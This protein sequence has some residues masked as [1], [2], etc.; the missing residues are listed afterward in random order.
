MMMNSFLFRTVKKWQ[1][2]YKMDLIFNVIFNILNTLLAADVKKCFNVDAPW[3]QPCSSLK[4]YYFK[5]ILMRQ[6][7]LSSEQFAK[8]NCA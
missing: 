7:T 8:E 3:F 4:K 6:Q 1:V 5:D 2:L